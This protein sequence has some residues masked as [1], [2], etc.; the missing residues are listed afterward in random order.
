MRPSKIKAKDYFTL[1]G[2]GT[3]IGQGDGVGTGVGTDNGFS[4]GS[5]P[6]EPLLLFYFNIL[7]ALI[8]HLPFH[9]IFG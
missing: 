6:R 7:F 3:W 2:F 8:V 1:I 9:L 5:K 4:P